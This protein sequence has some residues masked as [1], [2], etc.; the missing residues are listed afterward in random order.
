MRYEKPPSAE[1]INSLNEALLLYAT[2]ISGITPI[3]C[4]KI[5]TNRLP[6]R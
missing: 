4:Q 5:K 6:I 1:Y 3:S 2:V